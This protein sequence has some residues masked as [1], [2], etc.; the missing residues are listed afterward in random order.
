MNAPL[1]ADSACSIKKIMGHFSS[2]GNR[3]DLKAL[4]IFN[5][6]HE[7]ECSGMQQKYIRTHLAN[8]LGAIDV[9]IA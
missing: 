1:L 4:Y 6:P 8:G 9:R 3:R 5:A 2:K 7:G